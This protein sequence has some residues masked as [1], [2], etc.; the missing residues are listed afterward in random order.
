MRNQAVLTEKID[1]YRINVYYDD[2]PENPRTDWDNASHMVVRSRYLS[3]E[4]NQVEEIINALCEKYG[5]NNDGMDFY[6]VIDALNKFI[7]IKPI[8]IYVHSGMT[9]FFGR[10]TDRWDSGVVGFGY[11]EHEDLYSDCCGR[12]KK[13]H[14]DWR[15][16]CEAVMRGEMDALDRTVRGEVFGYVTEELDDDGDWVEYDS[17]WGFFMDAEEVI[18]EAKLNLPHEVMAEAV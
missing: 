18:E 10:P 8:S 1:N 7:V 14:P 4:N 11:M 3:T 15:D 12:N 17:C 9:V 16:Q 6:E 5:I 2:E 13:A